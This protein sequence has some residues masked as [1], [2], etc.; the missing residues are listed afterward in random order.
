MPT[1]PP[2]FVSPDSLN[3]AI[4]HVLRFGENDIFPSAFEYG[5]YKA[6][7]TDALSHLSKIDLSTYETGCSLKLLVPKGKWGYRVAAQLDPFDHLLYTAMIHEVATTIEGFRIAKEKKV[8]CAYRL[9]IDAKGQFFQRNSG[10]PDFHERSEA[11]SKTAT[12]K[13]VV[14]ADISDFYN[15]T[16][17]HR[18]QN[19]LSS[20]NVKDER[21]NSV[22]A[23]LSNINSGHH[24]RGLPVGPSAS[25]LLAEACLA[26][27]DNFLIRKGYSHTRYVDDFRIFCANYHE[28][29]S[30]LHDLSEYLYTAHRLSFQSSKTQI[31]SK[32][33]FRKEELVDPEQLEVKSKKE[34]IQEL[35]HQ[36]AS[37]HYEGSDEDEFELDDSTEAEL[38]RDTIGDLFKS[39][40][41]QQHLQFGLA[42]YLLRRA[43]NLKSRII[44]GDVLKNIEFLLP[45]FRDVTNYLVQVYDKKK[46]EQVG[47]VLRHLITKSSYRQLPFL[48]CWVLAAFAKDPLLCDGNVA[49]GIAE[50]SDSQIRDRVS[51]LIAKN[52]RLVDWVRARKET[53][54]NSTPFGQ[55]AIIWAA[56]ILPKDERNH[57]LKGISH[58][59]VYS[60]AL[61]AKA[62]LSG[63]GKP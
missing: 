55:R 1:T 45:V 51:A 6:Q 14:C 44:L 31:M 34:K 12:C 29:V 11:F 32:D 59:P 48:Q 2:D 16:S 38:L 18:I 61:L 21:A 52:Y 5:A 53:W 50:K 10:W 4:T 20:A 56:P 13:F 43:T 60:T 46:P 17:H 40:V 35:F 47:E 33:D 54:L 28:A 15:Q 27:V 30:A 22:E 26:D 19:A 37:A 41:S 49:I 58:Y 39:L 36:I 8:T 63:A 25:I 42:R 7:W 3:W 24:S 57:W 23:F 9:D 62:V